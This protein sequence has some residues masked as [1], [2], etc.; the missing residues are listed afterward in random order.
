MRKYKAIDLGT[1]KSVCHI[2]TSFSGNKRKRLHFKYYWLCS[3]CTASASQSNASF[4]RSSASHYDG[5]IH[6]LHHL[7][8]VSISVWVWLTLSRTLSV[9]MLLSSD[10]R[11][12]EKAGVKRGKCWSAEGNTGDLISLK[13]ETFKPHFHHSFFIQAWFCTFLHAHRV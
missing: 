5:L 7:R 6:R 2:C 10:Y 4:C 9:K 13:M 1:D 12:I 3:P 11:I 8:C